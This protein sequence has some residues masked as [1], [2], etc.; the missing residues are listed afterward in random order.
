MTT[1]EKLAPGSVLAKL[2]TVVRPE[3]RAEVYIPAPNNPVF[4][5]DQC[6]VADLL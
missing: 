5:S 1:I 2:M 6:V 4:I 3:F